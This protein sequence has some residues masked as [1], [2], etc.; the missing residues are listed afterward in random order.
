MRAAHMRE[1]VLSYTV[2][3]LACLAVIFGIFG[4]VWL[5]SSIRSVEYEI[6]ALQKELGGVLKERKLLV[7]ERASLFSI[8]QVETAASGKLGLGFPDR[9][10]GR[11]ETAQ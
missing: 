5:R 3:V 11:V 2:K 10:K 6:G 7:A 1:S 8:Q 4:L 9:T